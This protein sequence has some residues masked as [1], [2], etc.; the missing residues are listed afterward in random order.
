M[1]E[2]SKKTLEK[3]TKE[4]LEKMGIKASV[5]IATNALDEQNSFTVEIDTQD[6][7]FLIGRGGINLTAFQHICRL[8]VRK[9]LERPVNFFIDVNN[10]RQKNQENL[11]KDTQKAIRQ[12]LEKGEEVEMPPMNAYERRLVHMEAAENENIESESIGDGEE[13]RTI[14]RPLK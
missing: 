4:M 11:I 2:E 7:S 1:D 13:R 6:S 3:I 5:K 8:L 9:K 10:Y 12:A 14:I